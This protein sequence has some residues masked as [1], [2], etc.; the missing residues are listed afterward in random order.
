MGIC[1]SKKDFED[2]YDVTSTIYR[3][4]SSHI[5]TCKHKKTHQ[6]KI[7]KYYNSSFKRKANLPSNE[8]EMFKKI[9]TSKTSHLLKSEGIYEDVHGIYIVCPYYKH[10]LFT[11]VQTSGRFKLNTVISYLKQL[12]EGLTVIHE[13]G[14][15]HGD[16][17]PEN[18]LV[19][20]DKNNVVICDYGMIKKIG[21]IYPKCI[22][23]I[24]KYGYIPPE[25]IRR[26]SMEI[27]EKQDIYPLGVITYIMIYGSPMYAKFG[28]IWFDTYHSSAYTFPS[29]FPVCVQQIVRN[30][31][32]IDPELRPTLKE[33]KTSLHF[34]EK[35]I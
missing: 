24:G 2:N 14:Y 5:M 13:N 31:T 33:I 4:N 21:K 26:T 19:S 29:D 17:S 10:D 27:T 6:I 20:S 30:M 11:V 34:I 7:V 15:I 12:I 18:I 9:K 3:G 28:D 16:L 35:L 32:N 22:L 8:I 23:G 25:F 1:D